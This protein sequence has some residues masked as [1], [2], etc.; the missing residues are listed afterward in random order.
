MTDQPS[1][2]PEHVR[3][4]TRSAEAFPEVSGPSGEVF[5]VMSLGLASRSGLYVG[6]IQPDSDDEGDTDAAP[7]S[8]MIST[9]EVEFTADVAFTGNA[10]WKI[11]W[12]QTAEPSDFWVLYKGSKGAARN[13]RTMRNRMKDGD[14]RRCWYGDEARDKAS[15]G[16]AVTV[17]MNDDPNIS[18]CYPAHPGGPDLE[19]LLG[20]TPAACGGRKEFRAWLVAVREDDD[21]PAENSDSEP[22]GDNEP[23]GDDY[24]PEMVFLHHIHWHAVYECQIRGGADD[25]ALAYGATAGSFILGHGPGQG[26]AAPVLTGPPPR[27]HH[28]DSEVVP[29]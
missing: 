22:E 27:P 19:A 26:E 14:S 3:T 15:P 13:R 8:H 1:H 29:Q 21:Q 17:T 12:V 7:E 2:S 10:G 9:G 23:G 25:P 5:Q 4:M 28:E 11:G 16:A 6:G 20:W 24:R 18:F